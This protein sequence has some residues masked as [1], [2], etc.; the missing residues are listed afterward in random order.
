MTEQM[1][2]AINW[3]LDYSRADFDHV[4]RDGILSPWVDD[5]KGCDCHKEGFAETE[6]Q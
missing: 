5:A 6:I 1:T 4:M 2:R 3:S